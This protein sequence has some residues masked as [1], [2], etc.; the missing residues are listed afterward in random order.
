MNEVFGVVAVVGVIV[1][2]VGVMIGFSKLLGE[3]AENKPK[4]YQWVTGACTIGIFLSLVID[5]F[6]VS[7]GLWGIVVVLFM[8][9]PWAHAFWLR[10]GK[11]HFSSEQEAKEKVEN[12]A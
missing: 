9:P 10:D 11:D 12:G 5:A 4:I 7:I 8:I 3:L 1:L 6:F 2:L